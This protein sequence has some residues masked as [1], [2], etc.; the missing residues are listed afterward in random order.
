MHAVPRGSLFLPA[1]RIGQR[2]R[3]T[4]AP[5]PAIYSGESP[6]PQGRLGLPSLPAGIRKAINAISPEDIGDTHANSDSV[7]E[8]G[9]SLSVNYRKTVSQRSVH[10][11]RKGKRKPGPWRQTRTAQ[12]LGSAGP[13]EAGFRS[14]ARAGDVVVQ[15]WQSLSGKRITVFAPC[16]LVFRQDI[17]HWTRFYVSEPEDCQRVSW[18]RFE[19]EAEKHG[20]SRI[21]K[22]SVRELNPRE[23]LLIE[24]LWR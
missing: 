16:S 19:G 20:L 2:W 24:G 13:E 9:L 12:S 17:G 6:T 18:T 4:R 15:I 21:S 1:R 14:L 7:T 22:D 8:F 23:V 5:K 10:S 3:T 11:L